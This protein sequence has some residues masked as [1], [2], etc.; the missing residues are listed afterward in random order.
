[1]SNMTAVTSKVRPYMVSS[2]IKTVYVST[3][4]CD[5]VPRLRNELSLDSNEY[6]IVSPCDRGASPG[7][8]HPDDTWRLLAEIEMMRHGIRCSLCTISDW[9]PATFFFGLMRSNLCTLVYLVRHSKLQ[10]NTINLVHCNGCQE[11]VEIFNTGYS[12]E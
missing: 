3:D 8:G 5:V 9:M 4:T 6:I 1:M 12:V 7:R 2:G 11:K 10:K